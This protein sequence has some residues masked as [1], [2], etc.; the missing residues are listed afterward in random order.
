MAKVSTAKRILC[1][2]GFR[3]NG[4]I[5]KKSMHQ[6][7]TD[8]KKL[9]KYELEFV[10]SPFAYVRNEGDGEIDT[11]S[12]RQWWYGTKEDVTTVTTYDTLAESVKFVLEKL[13]TTKDCVGIWG[14][15]QGSVLAQIV[16]Y[17]LQQ[18]GMPLQCLILSATFPISDAGE[19]KR[20][21]ELKLTCP[22]LLMHGAKDTFVERKRA[23]VV[24]EYIANCTLV[25]HDGGHYVSTTKASRDA[26]SVFI[27]AALASGSDGAASTAAPVTTVTSLSS[28]SISAPDTYAAASATAAVAKTDSIGTFEALTSA[29]GAGVATTLVTAASSVPILTSASIAPV[30]ASSAVLVP[31]LACQTPLEADIASITL[32]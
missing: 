18:A 19:V 3:Q 23:L 7:I 16:A 4:S 20:T 21:A 31:A 6:Y 11:S 25:E 13:Q 1:L 24:C 27:S 8:C 26:V 14:F 10:D 30:S 32:D 9:Q 22:T 17:R 12:F 2:H 29:S 5:L 28:S 15:S